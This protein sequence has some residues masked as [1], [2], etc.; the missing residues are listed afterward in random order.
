M[1]EIEVKMQNEQ[2]GF[3]AYRSAL[4]GKHIIEAGAGTGK[5]YNIQ[6]LFLRLILEGTPVDSILVVTFTEMAT[7]ELQERLRNILVKMK[8]ACTLFLLKRSDEIDGQVQ[9]FF[10]NPIPDLSQIEDW[11][12]KVNKALRYF[13]SAPVSTIHGFCSSMLREKAFESGLRYGLN[14][15]ENTDALIFQL[16]HEYW[17]SFCENRPEQIDPT[18]W[19]RYLHLLVTLKINPAFLQKKV[20]SLISNCGAT[21]VWDTTDAFQNK[22]PEE[23]EIRNLLFTSLDKL[24][25]ALLD[26][27][28][29]NEDHEL[30]LKYCPS[31]LDI[32]KKHPC[33]KLKSECQDLV[34]RLVYNHVMKNLPVEKECG[35]VMTYNDLLENLKDRLKNPE[36]GEYLR[37]TIREK[38]TYALVDEF[39][40]TD[41][42]QSEIFNSIF[43]PKDDE[44]RGFFMIGDPKQAIY[45]F[46]GGDIYSYT[47]AV[48]NID[49]ECCHT[50]LN[51][52]R[53]SLA[54]I[55][56]MNDLFN[57]SDFFDAS[58]DSPDNAGSSDVTDITNTGDA[59]NITNV[60]NIT[61]ATDTGNNA[62]T[63]KNNPACNNDAACNMEKR[64]KIKFEDIRPSNK[65][66]YFFW[67]GKNSNDHE[68]IADWLLTAGNVNNNCYSCA[69][70]E[71]S[72]LVESQKAEVKIGESE[73]R[74]LTYG[75]I[76]VLTRKN[77]DAVNLSKELQRRGIPY[78]LRDQNIFS[79]P[80]SGHTL[81]VIQCV[82]EPDRQQNVLKLLGCG[83][84]NFSV[85][86][87]EKRL[88]NSSF[89]EDFQMH[90][91]KLRGIWF[92]KSFM[93]MFT[94][95]MTT[96]LEAILQNQL[97][98]EDLKQYPEFYAILEKSPEQAIAE[99]KNG[100]TSLAV[101][102]QL[103][104]LL[105][106]KE[107]QE[108][109][110]PADLRNFLNE[111]I[112]KEED[113]NKFFFDNSN[114]D[115]DEEDDQ[116][117]LY[118][119]RLP[120]EQKAVTLLTIHS[121]KGLEFPVVFILNLNMEPGSNHYNNPTSL[122]YHNENGERCVTIQISSEKK[123]LTK[124]EDLNE[125]RRLLYVAVTRARF[126]C[127]FLPNPEKTSKINILNI[128]DKDPFFDL[129]E[130]SR[131]KILS[132][133]VTD[134]SSLAVKEFTKED[135]E[136]L[137]NL[138]ARKYL[139]TVS[140]SSI[141]PNHEKLRK[142]HEELLPKQDGE[143][144]V[145]IGSQENADLSMFDPDQE[146]AGGTDENEP[147]EVNYADSDEWKK[148]WDKR[149]QIFKIRS[150]KD[151][152][153]CLH[154]LF[155]HLN[156]QTDNDED[157]NR[158]IEMTPKISTLLGTR[159]NKDYRKNLDALRQMIQGVMAQDL[160]I[161]E[162]SK[163]LTRIQLRTIKPEQR[164]H[165]L[166][167]T[168]HLNSGMNKEKARQG[169]KDLA[170]KLNLAD[171]GDQWNPYISGN[172][173]ITGSIDLLFR[174]P[175]KNDQS[176]KYYILDWKSNILG[177]GKRNPQFGDYDQEKLGDAMNKSFYPLQ[178][179]IY[180]VAFLRM[181]RSVMDQD[182]ELTKE[183]YEKIFGG[184]FYVYFRG[185]SS[186]NKEAMAKGRGVFSI[187]PP[188]ELV[189]ELYD[190]IEMEAD[191]ND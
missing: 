144:D 109:L 187:R 179:M 111:K 70:D 175:E 75:D 181:Y 13:D 177:S 99:R 172:S 98:K 180:T 163:E 64:I 8:A 182:F 155:E 35:N 103:S 41:P 152:G 176:D 5:T 147:E 139:T 153:T 107:K 10:K 74:L 110:V 101:F 169:L 125:L 55:K 21:I 31:M 47:N 156:F 60:T 19:N 38:F 24:N 96:P 66:H 145:M 82:L 106:G 28:K 158:Q 168:W 120:S 58:L 15:T 108:K 135:Q 12:H 57:I 154:E 140:Y 23:N 114:N 22:D 62:N 170:Q 4:T 113:S 117:D 137:N 16:I 116:E 83:L 191:N 148:S 67:D 69:A 167:F 32:E 90:L 112:Q 141:A 65:E 77:T 46:R 50:L 100:L 52:F 25:D 86:D 128:A 171:L 166:S 178:Y 68:E 122:T 27:E 84:F 29:D 2:N 48:E 11:K 56:K 26:S 36:I 123:D 33:Y 6:I 81:L 78:F 40:D 14:F 189:K 131:N 42:V 129:P 160:V 118:K 95:L 146:K 80:E 183:N 173:A 1:T 126:L 133:D 165:E 161:R 54:Y 102:S 143:P 73:P 150:G 115:S 20:K 130:D 37:K 186:V 63:T 61:N 7:A 97:L 185:I 59:I 164:Q 174:V 89:F 76:A 162:G 51:N 92:E 39:Q 93:E 94:T 43:E 44:K 53:S 88:R 159:Q 157:I 138:N 30:A 134:S 71:I 104:A 18:V 3:N 87:Y 119:L 124:K 49:S 85:I 91:Q 151:A 184:V 190:L 105:D 121:S 188:F 142:Y 132:N 34:Y 79:C 72:W 45:Q 136:K 149:E 9:E 17:T 127:R